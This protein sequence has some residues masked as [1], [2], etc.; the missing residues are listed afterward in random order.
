MKNIVVAIDFKDNE[1]LVLDKAYSFSKA[2]NSKLWLVHIAAPDPDFVGYEVGPDYIRET[3]AEELRDEHKKIQEYAG[4]L[5][6]KGIEAEALLIQGETVKTLLEKA[7]DLN[8]E[9]IIVGHHNHNIFYQAFI[10][11]VSSE[12]L[13]ESKI[14]ILVI[15]YK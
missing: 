14:P 13:N 3:R 6:N 2:F 4:E 15:P 5:V 8:S 11:S 1:Q 9:L 12:V 7:E 10:G